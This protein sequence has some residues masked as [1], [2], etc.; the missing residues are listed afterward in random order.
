MYL[1]GLYLSLLWLRSSQDATIFPVRL[2]AHEGR[3]R[4]LLHLHRHRALTTHPS[5]C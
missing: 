1:C 2:E 4:V 5:L 3:G